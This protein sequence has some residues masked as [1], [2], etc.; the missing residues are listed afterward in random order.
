MGTA[1]AAG[2][3]PGADIVVAGGNLAA[4]LSYG[5]VTQAGVGTATRSATAAWSASATR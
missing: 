3:G 1:A 2:D 5:D 4:S